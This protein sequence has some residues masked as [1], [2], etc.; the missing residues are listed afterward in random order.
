MRHAISD[1]KKRIVV[2]VNDLRRKNPERVKNLLSN[3]SEEQLAFSRALKDFI[4]SLSPD[5]AKKVD[6]FHVGF[7]GSFGS[8][9]VTPR[10]LTNRFLGSLI[11]VEG[12]VTKCK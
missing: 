5:Y 2:D 7:Q 12:I 3:S 6:F 11:C 4:F 9:H 8:K 1:Q 10:T